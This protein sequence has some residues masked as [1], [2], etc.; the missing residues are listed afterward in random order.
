MPTAK[1]KTVRKALKKRASTVVVIESRIAVKDTL[2]P[3]KVT[4]AK[5]ILRNTK[6]HDPKIFS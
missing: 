6:F 1:K 3:E 5:K 2:F 4:E